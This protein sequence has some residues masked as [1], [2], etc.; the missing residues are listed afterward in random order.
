MQASL[1]AISGPRRPP[2]ECVLRLICPWDTRGEGS[3]L[4]NAIEPY[5]AAMW[6]DRVPSVYVGVYAARCNVFSLPEMPRTKLPLVATAGF[7]PAT[8]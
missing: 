4:R 3:P 5:F 1:I 6:L 7:E 2:A 8:P